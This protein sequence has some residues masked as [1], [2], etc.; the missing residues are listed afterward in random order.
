MAVRKASTAPKAGNAK[1]DSNGL[2]DEAANGATGLLVV[3]MISC[4][5]FPDAGKLL[6]AAVTVSQR[7]AALK[8]RCRAAGVPV[9]YANDNQGRWRSTS[10]LWSNSP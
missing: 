10:A 4:W 9:I 2:P 6:P 5:D 7:I 8:R 1:D 3:D